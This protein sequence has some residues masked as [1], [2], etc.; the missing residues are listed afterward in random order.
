MSEPSEQNMERARE[1]WMVYQTQSDP[2]TAS[3][4]TNAELNAAVAVEVMGWQW[5]AYDRPGENSAGYWITRDKGGMLDERYW[6][7]ATDFAA[8]MNDVAPEVG[9]RSMDLAITVFPDEFIV[10]VTPHLSLEW[11]CERRGTDKALLPRA[12]CEAA[13]A[14][15][16]SE[17]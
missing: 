15:V 7:P 13:L 5:R 2:D 9:R 4:M 6:S 11:I 8:T 1:L 12:I 14:A 17:G 10:S 3:D 16:R